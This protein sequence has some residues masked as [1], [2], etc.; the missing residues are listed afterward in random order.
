MPCS[1]THTYVTHDYSHTR[2]YTPFLRAQSDALNPD[3]DFKCNLMSGCDNM[4]A[5]KTLCP[6]IAALI[7]TVRPPRLA[8]L[9]SK[10]VQLYFTHNNKQQNFI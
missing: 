2:T 8:Q 5:S 7:N 10:T 9:M 6:F 3:L 1:I 4:Y